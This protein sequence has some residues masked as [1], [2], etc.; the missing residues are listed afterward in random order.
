MCF[1]T[2]DYWEMYYLFIS[3][4][5]DAIVSSWFLL[6]LY[7]KNLEMEYP[8]DISFFVLSS[9]VNDESKCEFFIFLLCN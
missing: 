5:K 3:T 7:I 6:L 8:I 1:K 2:C 9:D 4:H